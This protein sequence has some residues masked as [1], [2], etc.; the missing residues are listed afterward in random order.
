MIISR[1]LSDKMKAITKKEDY[2]QKGTW[3]KKSV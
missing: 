3:N 1:L 2:M